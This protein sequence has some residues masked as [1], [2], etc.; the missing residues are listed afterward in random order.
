MGGD[1]SR[2]ALPGV[3]RDDPP[4]ASPDPGGVRA[5][6]RRRPEMRRSCLRS[7]RAL[8]A[9]QPASERGLPS[10]Y[11]QARGQ[12]TACSYSNPTASRTHFVVSLKSGLVS[13]FARISVP[14]AAPKSLPAS[15][16]LRKWTPATIRLCA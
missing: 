8:Q 6:L 14:T 1:C 16:S 11:M 9:G 12:L 5:E 2:R 7:P 3:E 10:L 15:T 13:G 4:Q